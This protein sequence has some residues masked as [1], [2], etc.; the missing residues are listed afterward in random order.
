MEKAAEEQP[1]NTAQRQKQPKAVSSC[2]ARLNQY[3]CLYTQNQYCC[4]FL[5]KPFLIGK[6]L[7][8][9]TIES[10]P[11]YGQTAVPDTS[12][13]H[14]LISFGSK[15]SRQEKH[16]HFLS[17]NNGSRWLDANSCACIKSD[18][19]CSSPR[20]YTHCRF[21]SQLSVLLSRFF[22]ANVSA[23]LPNPGLTAP[24]FPSQGRDR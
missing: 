18:I 12:A 19:F 3:L 22:G 8:S 6:P 7:C 20:L 16:P 11:Q 24:F 9:P 4:I 1:K 14:P 5:K 13:I 21:Q 2:T 17:F 23:A 10:I 15:I